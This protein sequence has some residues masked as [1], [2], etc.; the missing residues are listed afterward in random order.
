[1][2]ELLVLG[3]LSLRCLSSM[4]VATSKRPLRMKVW[5]LLVTLDS[6][7]DLS[8]PQSLDHCFKPELQ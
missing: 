3:M 4:L 5:N 2:S 6:V 7:K 8:H 1:M